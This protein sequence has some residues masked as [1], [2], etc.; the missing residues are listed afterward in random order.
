MAR[1]PSPCRQRPE[2][3]IF[4]LSSPS[5]CRTSAATSDCTFLSTATALRLRQY[6]SRQPP[7]PPPPPVPGCIFHIPNTRPQTKCPQSASSQG[8]QASAQSAEQPSSQDNQ[9][10]I[11]HHHSPRSPTTRAAHTPQPSNRAPPRPDY[12][13]SNRQSSSAS[14]AP[15]QTA[16]PTRPRCPTSNNSSSPPPSPS[17]RPRRPGTPPRPTPRPRLRHRHHH[18]RRGPTRPPPPGA[19]GAARPQSL[20]VKRTQRRARSAGQRPSR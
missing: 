12:P 19:C 16:S 7:P 15:W 8:P 1:P 5:S 17:R 11:D 6:N 10:R 13:Q 4:H 9:R 14:S 20:K 18:Q 2:L 3:S